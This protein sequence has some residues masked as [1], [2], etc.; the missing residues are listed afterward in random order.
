MASRGHGRG[1]AGEFLARLWSAF[2]SPDEI[3]AEG[4]TYWL[5]DRETGVELTAY[6][7]A[8][9]PAYG[10]EPQYRELV[11]AVL[12]ALDRM[13]DELPLVECDVSY[14]DESGRRRCGVRRGVPFDAGHRR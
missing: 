14:R 4:F 10:V 8:G 1:R 11:A 7:G 3:G 2:G 13:I 5:R 12:P 6:L 9:G